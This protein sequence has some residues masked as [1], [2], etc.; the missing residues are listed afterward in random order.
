MILLQRI[1]FPRF[2]FNLQGSHLPSCLTDRRHRRNS[3]SFSWFF[4]HD[5]LG[6]SRGIWLDIELSLD[7]N[8]IFS[9]FLNVVKVLVIWVKGAL[10]CTR[11]RS[12]KRT[13]K[14]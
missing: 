5:Y 3:W 9:N 10:H 4:F 6:R 7:L 2:T 1:V 14:S 13:P 12:K 11:R 8:T